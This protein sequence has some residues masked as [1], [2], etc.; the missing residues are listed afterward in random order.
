[1]KNSFENK[2][3]ALPVREHG[4][5]SGFPKLFYR[6]PTLVSSR[7][8]SKGV[9]SVLLSPDTPTG[10]YNLRFTYKES[11]VNRLVLNLFL[12]FCL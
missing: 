2:N 9:L 5:I 4:Y 8:G 10:I 3:A 7:S 12:L 6:F 1:M 11:R